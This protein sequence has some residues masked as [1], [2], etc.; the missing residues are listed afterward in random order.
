M[1]QSCARLDLEFRQPMQNVWSTES[2]RSNNL[3]RANGYQDHTP[4]CAT[5]TPG[6]SW[7]QA[8]DVREISGLRI[9]TETGKAL[10]SSAS[11]RTLDEK[12]ACMAG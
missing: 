2:P 4:V 8:T 3:R 1:I 5:A 6:K 10:N 7:N 9:A 12:E 11:I